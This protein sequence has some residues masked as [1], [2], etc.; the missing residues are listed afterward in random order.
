MLSGGEEEQ[1]QKC[2]WMT[3]KYQINLEADILPTKCTG[4]GSALAWHHNLGDLM[5]G[6]SFGLEVSEMAQKP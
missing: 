3:G 5:L 6:A 4:K 1:N 2:C